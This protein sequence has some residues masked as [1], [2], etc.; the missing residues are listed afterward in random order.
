LVVGG[1]PS[2]CSSSAALL[3]RLQSLLHRLECALKRRNQLDEAVDS[4]LPFPHILL[5]C[6]D[7]NGVHACY[8][9]KS[10]AH[11]LRQFSRFFKILGTLSQEA[12]SRG[13]R[14]F[15]ARYRPA[16]N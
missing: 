11:Q 7:N 16:E 9:R 6:L 3:R 15:G 5:Q 14:P 4:N 13:E 1:P 10:P 8:R 12:A 2:F